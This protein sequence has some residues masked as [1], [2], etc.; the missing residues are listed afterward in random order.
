[1]VKELKIR[2]AICCLHPNK[3]LLQT[4][5]SFNPNFTAKDE[6]TITGLSLINNR[7]ILTT[8]SCYLLFFK[9][10]PNHSF[11]LASPTNGSSPFSLYLEVNDKKGQGRK[12]F[13]NHSKRD[14][15]ALLSIMLPHLMYRAISKT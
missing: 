8:P 6:N 5:A 14:A 9:R 12:N 7:L 1:M 11:K 3:N 2:I 13:F 4:L 10:N 15:K